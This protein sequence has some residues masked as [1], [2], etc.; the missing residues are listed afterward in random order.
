MPVISWKAR[1][2][3]SDSYLWVVNVS[4]TT[5]MLMPRNGADAAVNQANSSSCCS[6]DNV[7]GCNSVSIQ[8][9][10]LVA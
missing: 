4:E 5:L 9:A 10:A 6:A 1:V 3:T 7:D 8:R 2:S